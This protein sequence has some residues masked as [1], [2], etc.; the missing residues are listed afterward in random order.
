MS[1]IPIL[2]RT[3]VY[4]AVLAALIAV[5]GGIAGWL[6]AGAE[7]LLSALVGTAMA[8]VF[9]GLT[10]VSILLAFDRG[11]GGFFG[12]VMGAWLVKFVLFLILA[13]LLRDQPWIQPV[14]LFA[15]LVAAVL[16][17]LAVDLIVIARSRLPY[18]SDVT[19]PEPGK[20]E[21]DQ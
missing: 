14:V 18:A 1:A 19:L 2:K 20:D 11:V 12:I 9:L 8:L 15:C 4:G 13:M 10:S 16:G 21:A 5:A 3:L 6:V 17:T 7:G